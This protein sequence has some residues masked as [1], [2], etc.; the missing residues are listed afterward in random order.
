MTHRK[1]DGCECCCSDMV[2]C[3][4]GLNSVWTKEFDSPT[5]TISTIK[6]KDYEKVFRNYDEIFHRFGI[7]GI[8]CSGISDH[9]MLLPENSGHLAWLCSIYIFRSWSNNLSD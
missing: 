5:R 6:N 7:G 4:K 9:A 3:S 2:K 8:E 1:D